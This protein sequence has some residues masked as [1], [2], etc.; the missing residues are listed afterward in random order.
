MKNVPYGLLAVSLFLVATSVTFTNDV[1]TTLAQDDDDLN[2]SGQG[3]EQWSVPVRTV[4]RDTR[5]VDR[6]YSRIR[7]SRAEPVDAPESHSTQDS[8]SSAGGRID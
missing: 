3:V 4:E 5:P 1:S 7:V 6:M 2:G 8:S